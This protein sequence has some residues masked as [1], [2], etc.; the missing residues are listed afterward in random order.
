MRALFNKARASVRRTLNICLRRPSAEEYF[1]TEAPLLCKKSV[2]KETAAMSFQLHP[3]EKAL[4]ATAGDC[5][6]DLWCYKSSPY[7]GWHGCRHTGTTELIREGNNKRLLGYRFN[8]GW[9]DRADSRYT[10]KQIAE[11]IARL[12]NHVEN[13]MDW[14]D[15][16][17]VHTTEH[18]DVVH[19]YYSGG[20]LQNTTASWL[21][22]LLLRLG[23]NF[24]PDRSFEWTLK[25]HNYGAATVPAI[26][27]FV[28]G[29]QH[30]TG[31]AQGWY[32]VF[33][34]TT[35]DRVCQL[36]VH[37]EEVRE[38]AYLLAEADRFGKKPGQYWLAACRYFEGLR[39]DP[40]PQQP[41]YNRDVAQRWPEAA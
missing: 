15:R 35:W 31:S 26:Q 8:K 7:F 34:Q 13:K 28:Q 36:L 9:Y 12:F 6:Q 40:L 29:S 19:V 5:D 18:S 30:Y 4:H 17:R 25:Q 10:N 32:D 22:T 23:G 41:T 39:N 20:W 38:K 33:R 27:R 24:G 37:T 3:E 11:N 21:A 2:P 1:E 14:W 16:T